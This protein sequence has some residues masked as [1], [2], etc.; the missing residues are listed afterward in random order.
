MKIFLVATLTLMIGCSR[1]D[2]TVVHEKSI[3]RK[4]RHVGNVVADAAAS[5]I[6]ITVI[7]DP[8]Y[9]ILKYQRGDVPMNRGVCSDVVIRAFRKVGMDLQKK[10]HEDMTKNF[11]AYPHK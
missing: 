6:G 5:Q 11:A 8:L 3:P 4:H 1:R 7:Y 10:I 2:D 9:V